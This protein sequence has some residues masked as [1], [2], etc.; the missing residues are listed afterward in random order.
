MMPDNYKAEISQLKTKDTYSMTLT[1]QFYGASFNYKYSLKNSELGLAGKD[2][3]GDEVLVRNLK[4]TKD[5]YTLV[6]NSQ[7]EGE[8]EMNCVAKK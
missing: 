2:K 7:R 4:K 5:S 8:L 1:Y 3:R 6:I